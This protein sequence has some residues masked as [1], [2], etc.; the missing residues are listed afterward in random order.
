M[1]YGIT[2]YQEGT[3]SCVFGKMPDKPPI[4][5]TY[6]YPPGSNLILPAGLFNCCGLSAMA[7]F[8]RIKLTTFADKAEY[9]A[10]LYKATGK[11]I[12]YAISGDQEARALWE[13]YE[14]AL[15]VEIGAE[16]LKA[17]PNRTHSS[18]GIQLWL[19]DL[20]NAVGKYITGLG[21]PL[22][23]PPKPVIAEPAVAAKK[24]RAP[25]KT[26][27]VKDVPA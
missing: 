8:N 1:P 19:V 10:G 4:P 13:S 9:L 18:S 12:L 2:N 23:E 11:T 5:G 6:Y 14:H 17:F 24:P 15:F 21:D 27:E 7:S 26:K 3:T 16:R 22:T 25:R 20:T